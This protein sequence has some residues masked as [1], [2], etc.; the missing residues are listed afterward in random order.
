MSTRAMRITPVL[1]LPSNLRAELAHQSPPTPL[2]PSR[3]CHL[4]PTPP[5]QKKKKTR[6][7]QPVRLLHIAACRSVS[8]LLVPFTPDRFQ[9]SEGGASSPEV[10]CEARPLDGRVRLHPD[11]SA[12]GFVEVPHECAEVES[13]H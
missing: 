7:K 6:S 3:R 4:S 2:H 11:A 5:H 12:E 13:M 8:L 9:T 10:L 1:L